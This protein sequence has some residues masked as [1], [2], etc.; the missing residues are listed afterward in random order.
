MLVYFSIFLK[1]CI[2][3]FNLFQVSP[4]ASESH[5]S[6]MKHKEEEELEEKKRL[7]SEQ[8][9]RMLKRKSSFLEEIRMEAEQEFDGNIQQ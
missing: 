9:E 1:F 7:F 4:L 3:H 6:L 8:Q 5:A 2:T